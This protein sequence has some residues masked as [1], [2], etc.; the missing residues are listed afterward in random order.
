[1]S[2]TTRMAGASSEEMDSSVTEQI[3]KQINTISGVDTVSSVSSEGI[4]I[5]TVQFSLEKDSA[6][7]FQEVQAKVNL[8]LPSLPSSADQ[9]TIQKMAPDSTPV[10]TFTLTAPGESIRNL[11]EYADKTLRPQIE[12]VSGV[13]QATISGG[14]LRQ[15]NITLDPYRLRAY[16]LTALSVRNALSQQNVEAPGGSLD[17][18]NTHISLQ[19]EGRYRSIE[20][21]KSLV[22]ARQDSQPIYL[23]DLATVTD[24]E[25]EASSIAR[26]NGQSTI[27][28]QVQKQSGTNT[29][30][31]VDQIK[32]RLESVKHL[33][34]AGY[35]VQITQDQSIFINASVHTLEEHL[36]LGSLLA[37]LVVLF[38]LRDWRSTIIAALAIPASIIAT[39]L[40][41][42]AKGFTL[43]TITMLALTLSVGI[44]ID[45][46]ILVLE[47]IVRFI[48]EKGMS[49][50][51]ASIAATK[52]IGLAVLATTLS[53]VAIFLP[54]AF[55]SGIVGRV[56]T[57]F[58]LTMAFAIL[59]SMLV[60]FT[61]TPMLT[62]RW[63]K[64]GGTT[65]KSHA[66]NKN[67]LAHRIET[68]YAQLIHWALHHR[69]VVVIVCIATFLTSVPLIG[70]VNKEF[71]SS[72]DQSQFQVSIQAPTGT[73]L[74]A[75]G[76]LLNQV[77]EDI[78]KRIP[79]VRYAV[80]TV[81]S[82]SQGSANK[83]EIAVRINEIGQR[84]SKKSAFDIIDQVRKE[85]VPK[86]PKDL[87]ITV[88][89]PSAF[90]GGG[91]M[92]A[93]QYVLT[94]PDLKVLQKAADDLIAKAKQIPSVTDVSSS[95]SSGNPS[96]K[97]V[98]DRAKAADLGVSATDL[99]SVVQIVAAG[100]TV[101]SYEEGGRRYDISARAQERYRTRVKDLNLFLVPSS[102]PE[103]SPVTLDQVTTVEESTAP[104]AIN[105][106]SRSR[107]V[108]L[109][110][111]IKQGASQQDV[112]NQVDQ[113]YKALHLGDQYQ[114]QPGG[115]SKELGKTFVAFGTAVALSFIFIYLI[116]AAQF[117]SWVHP[118]T[119]LVSLPL[120]VPFGLLALVVTGG[121]L[122]LNSLLGLLVLFGVVKKNSILQVDHANQLRAEG[123]QRED[124]IVQAS[125]DRLRPILMTTI[126]F[127]A[128]MIPL[129]ISTGVGSTTN[130]SV[131][132][133]IMGGQ[134]LSL[135]LTLVATPVIYSLMDD[136]TQSVARL[137]ARLAKS[138]G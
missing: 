61:L 127:V 8:A 109:S 80:V 41:M 51:E 58:G 83:G 21:L 28:V 125:Q 118:F 59:V 43:N 88:S 92:P 135:L 94:G 104:A 95:S 54:V 63:L 33:M 97:I 79:D 60:A 112:L 34:P 7:A 26:L 123:L 57:S 62:S 66:L 65:K 19:T 67:G 56:L 74:K 100:Q 45:D 115:M 116:L 6:V 68:K 93:I 46:A 48:H 73:S 126:A 11:T 128:G 130:R 111:N 113:A 131:G 107:Q 16:G 91:A 44:V 132:Y 114:G 122:N 136:L 4:S 69:P 17:Q 15:I 90:G 138:E 108:T 40:L 86:Y 101:S 129:V 42:W 85:I 96:A 89:A 55:M 137:K 99:A 84:K 53:L 23:S 2:I 78:R 75:T 27:L 22:V 13:G 98:I 12:S 76:E 120:S 134:T 25:K 47:N 49:P 121:S 5:V 124:A 81:G 105:R 117:E 72:D 39:F 103:G 70:L 3:E 71:L 50:K 10:L 102:K 64:A 14:Q 1:M 82:D 36:V 106:L 31:V 77:A 110:I 38:F 52:E 87:T 35:S 30:A 37:A 18:G 20:A 9:P 133:L 119:I 24:G 32:E 29:V